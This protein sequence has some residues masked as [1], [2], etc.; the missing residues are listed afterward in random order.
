MAATAQHMKRHIAGCRK[1]QMECSKACTAEQRKHIAAPGPATGPGRQRRE[2]RKGLAQQHRRGCAV[3]Q[4]SPFQQ[5]PP[6]T[7]TGQAPNTLGCGH[8]LGHGV[9]KATSISGYLRTSKGALKV[10]VQSVHSCAPTAFG[11]P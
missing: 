5:S 4:Q 9:R 2:Q 7:G 8:A 10:N 11:M 3:H 6:R 1:P